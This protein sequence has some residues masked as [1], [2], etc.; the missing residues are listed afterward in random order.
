MPRLVAIIV[1]AAV[2]LG[3]RTAAA[4]NPEIDKGEL[5]Y[6]CG[7]ARGKVVVNFKPDV[8]LPD[9]VTW[10]MGFTCKKFVYNAA[11]AGRS[12]KATIIVP[13]RM[14]VEQAWRT[15]LVALE[16]MGLTVVPR[17]DVLSVVE[18]GQAKV[19]SVPLY[20]KGTPS[21]RAQVVRKLF[22][23][24]HITP[25][26]LGKALEL[27]KSKH[28]EVTT[29]AELD[30]VL[31]TDFAD[32]IGGMTALVGE[33]D[34]PRAAETLYALKV[35]R[36]D[37]VELV[38]VVQELLESR[39]APA[40]PQRTGRGSRRGGRSAPAVVDTAPSSAAPSKLIADPRTNTL[41]IVG[42]DA[43]YQRVRAIVDRL[44]IAVDGEA[45]GS[46][47]LY[48]LQNAV[49]EE[50]AQT[51]QTLLTGG[52]PATGQGGRGGNR[53]APSSAAPVVQG[54]VRVAFDKPTNSLLFVATTRDYLAISQIVRQLDQRRRQV[55]IEATVF[56]VETKNGRELG[57]SAHGGTEKDG[58]LIIGGFQ[59]GAVSSA[60]PES[61]L[62][63]TGLVGGLFGKPIEGVSELIGTSVPSFGV[64]VHA[65]AETSLLD[66]LSEPHIL[67]ADNEQAVISVGRNIPYQSRLTAIPGATE[68]TASILAGTSVERQKVALTLKVTPHV[69]SDEQ[70]RLE[71]ELAKD[72][73]L[74]ESIGS[75]LG[76]SWSTSELT[77]T[78][79]VHNQETIVIGGLMA[80]KLDETATKIPVLGDIPLLGHLFRSTKK[81]KRKTNLL[82]LLT[83]HIV[84]DQRDARR[85]LDRRL[86]ERQEFLQARSSFA[87]R[88]PSRDVDYGRKRGLVEEI[89]RTV[90][91]IERERALRDQL[92]QELIGPPDGPI[93]GT[94][95]GQSTD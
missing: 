11:V 61:A 25:A 45:S 54:Q 49:A 90:T 78:V 94:R 77:N 76:P 59:G 16:T 28:G 2:I 51:L 66:I 34:R 27:L 53:P 26:E 73:V 70:I 24:E 6:R 46:I 13:E 82:V 79:V 19:G 22:R 29:L 42:S 18:S 58:G 68:D 81:T 35:R 93:V 1:A 10:A 56:E 4:D 72:D 55:Y 69:S 95:S 37:A 44:D 47:H 85:I 57:L 14:N 20:L 21:R 41:L 60:A 31:V 67:T 8:D 52:A 80:D 7:K 87:R 39:P 5:L 15:F 62:S 84:T 71:I 86:R 75:G 3:A 36:V 33:V 63:V 91:R 74:E 64:A 38:K 65:L 89:N 12:T 88:P 50:L 23:P 9:L 43:A 17:G 30:M 48:P 83:P 32:Q 92:E 40:A